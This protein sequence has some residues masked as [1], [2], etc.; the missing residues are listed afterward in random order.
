MTG[1]FHR[2][3][4]PL[5]SADL[6]KCQKVLET[7]CRKNRVRLAS[8]EAN[9]VAAIIIELYQQGV[10]CSAWRDSKTQESTLSNAGLLGVFRM[11]SATPTLR[12]TFFDIAQSLH[13]G[14]A[15]E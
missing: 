14:A 6:A 13:P 2:L 11:P 7:Y 9:G 15:L 4:E 12:G 8:E 10:R 5:T 3:D 1:R